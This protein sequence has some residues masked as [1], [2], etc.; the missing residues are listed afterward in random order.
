MVHLELGGSEAGS[1]MV[2]LDLADSKMASLRLGHSK[3]A[4][5]ELVNSGRVKVLKVIPTK[6]SLASL[7]A[8]PRMAGL[9]LEHSRWT[10]P[11]TEARVWVVP[12][13]LKGL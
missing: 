4:D 1:R 2:A 6:V 10:S 9:K 12:K 5:S 3:M 11:A 13:S 8:D 7:M